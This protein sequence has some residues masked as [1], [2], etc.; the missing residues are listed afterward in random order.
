MVVS[1]ADLEDQHWLDRQV[2]AIENG[3]EAAKAAVIDIAQN[4]TENR[5]LSR[6]HPGSAQ[7][8]VK[9]NIKQALGREIIVPLLAES[10]WSN[11]QIAA[12]AGVDEGTVRN[13]L[14][15][16]PQL[17]RPAETLGADGKLRPARVIREV[18]AEVIEPEES[19]MEVKPQQRHRANVT[20]VR[21]QI[22]ILQGVLAMLRPDEVIASAVPIVR[23]FAPTLSEWVQLWNNPEIE[24]SSSK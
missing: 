3:F 12:V 18:T 5:N 23:E 22:R 14:R 11:R 19:R 16:I 24:D 10:N 2:A 21:Q 20:E 6:L 9:A 15:N 1:K 13:E 17:E 7:E 4:W 8:Y